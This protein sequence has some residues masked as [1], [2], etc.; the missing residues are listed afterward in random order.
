M[1]IKLKLNEVININKTL[2][3]IIDDSHAKIN[4]LLKFRLLGLMKAIEAHVSNFELIK[5]E[6]IIEYG[7][8]NK[9]GTFQIS[10]DDIKAV[11]KFRK[12]IEQVL[13]S[14]VTICVDPFKPDE[15]FDKG[16][17]S[18]YLSGLYPIIRE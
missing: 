15:I 17:K 14:D 2:A 10:K 6:K 5:N 11:A 13:D 12:D 18:D 9:D 7:K 1:E 8:K 4:V 3:A 16:L